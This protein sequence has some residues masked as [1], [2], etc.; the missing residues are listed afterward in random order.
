[1][2]GCS[3][4]GFGAPKCN[5]THRPSDVAGHILEIETDVAYRNGYQDAADEWGRLE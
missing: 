5:C 2:N 3:V 1:M 4:F